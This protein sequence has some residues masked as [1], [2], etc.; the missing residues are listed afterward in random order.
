MKPLHRNTIAAIKRRHD[1]GYAAATIAQEF[2]L[3]VPEVKRIVGRRR[4]SRAG[5]GV[6]SRKEIDAIRPEG[7]SDAEWAERVRKV[8]GSV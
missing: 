1:H 4:K 3:L 2:G 6:V 7:L 8:F 5:R